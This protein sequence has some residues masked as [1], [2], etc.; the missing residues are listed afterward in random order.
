MQN[1]LTTS[2]AL[3]PPGGKLVA[4]LH[5]KSANSYATEIDFKKALT[6]TIEAT[7]IDVPANVTKTIVKNA[8]TPDPDAP[9]IT[10]KKGKPETTPTYATKR[11]SHYPTDT[12][13]SI[14][15]NETR[16]LPKPTN[17]SPTKSTPTSQP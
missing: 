4:T 2:T 3:R 17:T 8:A 10:N 7:C 1:R 12:S 16:R 9:I 13:P 5:D 14:P 11:T 6:T 15:N